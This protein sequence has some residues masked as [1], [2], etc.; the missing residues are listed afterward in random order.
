MLLL[1]TSGQ[2][3]QVD[4]TELSPRHLYKERLQPLDVSAKKQSPDSLG[5]SCCHTHQERKKQA[6]T[7]RGERNGKARCSL[8]VRHG[9]APRGLCIRPNT[10]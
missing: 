8:H 9:I 5:E 4:W 3:Q 10:K 7:E 1:E 6:S 2:D